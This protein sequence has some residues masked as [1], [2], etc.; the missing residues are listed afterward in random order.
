MKIRVLFLAAVLLISGSSFAQKSKKSKKA[1]KKEVA[2]N[3]SSEDV[4]GRMLESKDFTFLAHVVYPLGQSSRNLGGENYSVS[5][6]EERINSILP[7][8]GNV[9]SGAFG[10]GATE[11]LNFKGK[12]TK[13]NIRET[14][15]GYTVHVEANT[16][17]DDYTFILKV[18]KTGHARLTVTSRFKQSTS[19]Q[20]EVLQVLD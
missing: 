6:T 14:K 12:I 5:F 7:Y 11:G 20:G 10:A 17:R 9:Q 18:E 2:S 3:V 8:Y 15:K 4:V 19:F 16:S 1:D 13:F